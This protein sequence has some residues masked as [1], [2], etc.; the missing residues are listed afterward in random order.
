MGHTSHKKRDR[1]P[2]KS[3]TPEAKVARRKARTEAK[4]VHK[5]ESKTASRAALDLARSPLS[6][7]AVQRDRSRPRGHKPDPR[8]LPLR[9][10]EREQEARHRQTGRRAGNWR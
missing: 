4:R 6:D 1:S 3:K 5:A 7:V 9:T 8:Q 10:A 2:R